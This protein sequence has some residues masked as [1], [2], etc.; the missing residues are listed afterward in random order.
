MDNSLL[1]H[2]IR[3]I[4]QLLGPGL[5]SKRGVLGCQRP[6][7]LPAY[8]GERGV[9]FGLEGRCRLDLDPVGGW[10]A[11]QDLGQQQVERVNVKAAVEAGVAVAAMMEHMT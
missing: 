1:V 5:G 6:E 9:F 10:L 3:G 7:S 4:D 2:D 8:S 11:C